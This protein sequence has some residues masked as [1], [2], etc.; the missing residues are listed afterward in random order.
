MGKNI[1]VKL[2]KPL[3]WENVDYATKTKK[4]LVKA[5]GLNGI[6]LNPQV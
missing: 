3:E 6:G 1:V 4:N 2:P 5:K